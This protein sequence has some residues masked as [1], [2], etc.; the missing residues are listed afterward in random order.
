[1]VFIPHLRHHFHGLVLLPPALRSVPSDSE[2]AEPG[3]GQVLEA[4]EQIDERG[5][6]AT[7]GV[8]LVLI[9]LF[10]LSLVS[11]TS[12]LFQEGAT[13]SFKKAH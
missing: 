8:D 10:F 9:K 1:M 11:P 13:T 2:H 3:M 4:L 7:G 6:R 5:A 12:S